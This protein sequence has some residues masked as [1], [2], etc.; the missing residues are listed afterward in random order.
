MS[1]VPGIA[2]LAVLSSLGQPT[3]RIEIDRA[4]AARYGLQPGD[5][6]ST[7]A[8]AIGGQAAGHL[9]EDGSDRN[10]PIVVRLA[11]KY[12]DS[13]DAIRRITIG[14]PNPGGN[15]VV[16]I[17]LTDVAAVKLVS[18]AAFIYIARTSSATS[19]SSSACATAI[20]AARLSRPSTRSPSEVTLLSGYRLEW[21][22]EFGELQEAIGRLAVVVPL[23]LALICL[24]LFL[25]FGSI[26]DM[27]LAQPA[28]ICRWR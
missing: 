1:T 3:V 25:N 11:P 18:G 2:D 19:R 14:A 13:I 24:L 5:I 20:S 27:L 12:R 9:N 23:S 26:I 16:P 17:P 10:F 6:N 21:V 4:R 22:G 7:I 15:G 8:A 28:M